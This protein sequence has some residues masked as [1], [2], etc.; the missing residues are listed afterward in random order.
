MMRIIN[1]RGL[2]CPQPVVITKEALNELTSGTI[3][4]IVDNQE[5]SRNVSRLARNLGCK[6]KI[7]KQ[8]KDFLVEITKFTSR[9]TSCP[10]GQASKIEK[11]ETKPPNNIVVSIPSDT[12]GRG[13]DKLGK[14]LMRVFFPTLLEVNPKPK[15]LIFMNNGVKLTVEGSD[16]L[17]TLTKLE[18]G[19]ME[20]LVCGT[21]LDY[22][23]LK[24]KIRVGRISNF[25]EITETLLNA[26]KVIRM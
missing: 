9:L 17:T 21:C 16:C 19:G 11:K 24:E 22:F 2:A 10:V 13:N 12:I 23:G 6:V 14:T 3:E 1:A 26:D 25:F 20:L 5:A 8:D 7:N 18:K 4:V 15:K